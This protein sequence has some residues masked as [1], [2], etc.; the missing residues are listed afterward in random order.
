LICLPRLRQG[1]ERRKERKRSF[2]TLTICTTG[3]GVKANESKDMT[4]REETASLKPQT[5]R[6][7]YIR[8]RVGDR[9][10]GREIGPR[11]DERTRGH[12]ARARV[13]AIQVRVFTA[14]CILQGS[15]YFLHPYPFQPSLAGERNRPSP[16]HRPNHHHLHHRHPHSRRR[17]HPSYRTRGPFQ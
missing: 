2:L 8:S 1:S 11:V 5:H 3:R 4:R 13:N 10:R 16:N 12:D 14:V 15:P 7:Q 17:P 6:I 9:R